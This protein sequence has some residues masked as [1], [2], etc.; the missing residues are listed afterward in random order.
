MPSA[1]RDE[2]RFFMDALFHA[3]IGAFITTPD[4]RI[5]FV[6]ESLAR[7]IGYESAQAFRDAVIV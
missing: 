1:D 5:L 2:C 7:M 6:N 4:G 3:P